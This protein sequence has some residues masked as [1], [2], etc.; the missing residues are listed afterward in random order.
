[1]FSALLKLRET[2]ESE[3]L[4]ISRDETILGVIKARRIA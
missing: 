4:A 2:D 3:Y 1:M